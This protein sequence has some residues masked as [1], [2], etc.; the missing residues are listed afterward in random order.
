MLCI[1][2]QVWYC[3]VLGSRSIIYWVLGDWV[4][5][6]YALDATSRAT[7]IFVI[8][9]DQYADFQFCDKSTNL[10]D[11]VKQQGSL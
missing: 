9:H 1:V 2:Y 4:L 6:P 3:R 7:A 5:G 11:V 8:V 10:P